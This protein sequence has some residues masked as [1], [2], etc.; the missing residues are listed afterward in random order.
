ML[1]ALEPRRIYF[2]R[3]SVHCK[4]ESL[5]IGT[6]SFVGQLYLT[7]L[8]KETARLA[9]SFLESVLLV[10]RGVNFAAVIVN[11]RIVCGGIWA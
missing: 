2:R 6:V 1:G 3:L 8:L 11:N 7:V 9:A 10:G 4:H 5:R